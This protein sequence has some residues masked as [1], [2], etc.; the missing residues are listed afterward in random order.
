MERVRP[1][2]LFSWGLLG[3]TL[4]FF[5]EPWGLKTNCSFCLLLRSFPGENPSAR[6]PQQGWGPS[7]W[8]GVLIRLSCHPNPQLG[9]LL[10]YKALL[11]TR[12]RA[13]FHLKYSTGLE[14][15]MHWYFLVERRILYRD[16]LQGFAVY[17]SIQQSFSHIP[18]LTVLST[19]I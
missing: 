18:I 17:A 3:V 10:K 19:V 4:R 9:W 7:F 2:V 5:T 14:L 1:V 8:A 11:F 13:W 15:E 6:E 16:P 12:G